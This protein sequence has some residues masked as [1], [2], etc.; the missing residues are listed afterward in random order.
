MDVH[1]TRRSTHIDWRIYLFNKDNSLTT[2]THE[3]FSIEAP[4][5]N[6]F[7]SRSSIETSTIL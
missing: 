3:N 1:H 2:K 5:P 6:I 7:S 4:I